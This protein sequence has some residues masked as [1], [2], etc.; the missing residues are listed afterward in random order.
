MRALAQKRRQKAQ[1][2][3]EATIEIDEADYDDGD[4]ET[5]A[6]TVG[7]TKLLELIKGYSKTEREDFTNNLLNYANKK[8]K[9]Q[10]DNILPT[11]KELVS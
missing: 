4:S 10:I 5:S 7:T 8:D 1:E 2:E 11:L 9:R 6:E 3:V